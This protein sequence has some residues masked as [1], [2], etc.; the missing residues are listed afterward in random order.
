[1]L[2]WWLKPPY[3][4]VRTDFF[5]LCMVVSFIGMLIRAWVVLSTPAG[6]SGRN[7]QK[8]IAD[9]LNTS[10]IY[11]LCR[12]PLYLGNYLMWLGLLL[13]TG[14]LYFVIFS[15]LVFAFYYHRIII[16]EENFL[17]EKFGAP[18]KQW[19]KQTPRFFPKLNGYKRALNSMAWRF[20]FRREHSGWLAT[21]VIFLVL[22]VYQRWQLALSDLYNPIIV[23]LLLLALLHTLAIKALKHNQKIFG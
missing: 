17:A 5:A 2:T 4:V 11:S 8:Q 10:G 19:L 16:A 14:N 12:N 23:V 9:Q 15:S 21:V 1:M 20:I 22:D 3:C 13:F 6:T 18:Y 7:T